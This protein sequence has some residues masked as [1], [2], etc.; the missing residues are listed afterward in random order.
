MSLI[1]VFR[2]VD[3]ARFDEVRDGV[4]A[5]ETRAATPKYRAVNVGDELQFS[6]GGD[7][8]SKKVIKK[9]H[10]PSVEAMLAEIPLK[11]AFPDLDTVEQVKT[12][13]ANYPAYEEKIKQFGIIGFEL[14]S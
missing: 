5:I 13:Y 4:K 8:F 3:R 14:S 7:T 6:C 1:L 12:R 11:Q 9:F 2:E 10:W